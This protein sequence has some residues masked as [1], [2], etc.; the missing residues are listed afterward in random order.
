MEPFE[1]PKSAIQLMWNA[2]IFWEMAADENVRLMRS[3]LIDRAMRDWFGVEPRIDAVTCARQRFSRP[4]TAPQGPVRAARK[5]SL[6]LVPA[7]KAKAP[8]HR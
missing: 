6:Q 8:H 4:P 5:P 1:I 2:V 3:I 7:R